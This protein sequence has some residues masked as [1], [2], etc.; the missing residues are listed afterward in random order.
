MAKFKE[1]TAAKFQA[2][3]PVVVATDDKGTHYSLSPQ[4]V[5]HYMK[6][7]GNK[8]WIEEVLPSSGG[9]QMYRVKFVGGVPNE[10][11]IVFHTSLG[12]ACLAPY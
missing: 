9:E 12:E 8:A 6:E 7:W 10:S 2:L 5:M 1:G 3:P 11:V 4:A